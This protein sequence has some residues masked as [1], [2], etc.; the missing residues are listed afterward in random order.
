L[1]HDETHGMRLDPA[2]H[3]QLFKCLPDTDDAHATARRIND[4]VGQAPAE[5]LGDLVAHGLFALDTVWLFERR[6][7]KPTLLLDALRDQAARIANQPVHEREF[8]AIQL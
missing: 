4:R 7:V 5:L 2:K 3:K 6:R 1:R 8:S